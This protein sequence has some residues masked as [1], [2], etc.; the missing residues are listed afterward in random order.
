MQNESFESQSQSLT[1]YLV[2]GM[3]VLMVAVPV[4][5]FVLSAEAWTSALFAKGAY[6]VESTKNLAEQLFDASAKIRALERKL[7][8]NELEMTRLK[9]EARDTSRLRSLLELKQ[10]SKR[11]TIAAE[12]VSRNADNWFEQVVIDKGSADHITVGSAVISIS[13][14][15]GQVV[16]VDSHGAVVR[17]ITDP[18]QKLGVLIPRLGLTGI[19]VGNSQNLARIDFVPVG[20][21]VN[22]GDKVVT[23]GKAGTFPENHPVGSVVAV[24]RDAEGA[25]MEID[26]KLTENCYDLSHVLVL[27]PLEG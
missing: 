25:S 1:E 17:L 16:K 11:Q 2:L 12:V 20:T 4:S 21:N 19:L 3:L 24:R 18:D 22:V 6:Q 23:L 26:V 14:V 15:V 7:A 27:P 5:G 9:Q 10:K 13:G 8:Q